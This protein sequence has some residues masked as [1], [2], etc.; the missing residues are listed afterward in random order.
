MGR[1]Q[2]ALEAYDK[3]VSLKP[4]Y[5]EALN[6]KGLLLDAMGNHKDAIDAYDKALKVKPDF[7]AAWFNKA[8]AYALLSNKDD[9]LDS[10]QK[11]IKLN[12]GYKNTA[13]NTPDFAIFKGDAGF[14]ELV[15]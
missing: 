8:C 13:K 2:E 10:L 5:I 3:A 1:Q 15:K 4:D 11:A 6:N 7:D 12:P 9:A 14:E